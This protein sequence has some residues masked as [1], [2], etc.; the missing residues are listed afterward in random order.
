LT[1][2]TGTPWLK[3]VIHA[4]AVLPGVWLVWGYWQG[5]LSP[6]PIGV[7]IR[8]SGRYALVFLILSL[9]PTA[10]KLVVGSRALLR[11]RRIMGLYAFVYAALHFLAF[12]GLDYGFDLPFLLPALIEGRR[13]LAGLAA[14]I[15]LSPLAFTSTGGWV[16]RLG[17]NWRRLHRL[18]Y[19]ASILAV[20]HYAWSFKELRIMPVVTGAIVLLL[21]TMRIPPVANFAGRWRKHRD[22]DRTS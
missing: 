14:L 2:S 16:K 19:V 1:R 11:V 13:T 6:D 9:V 21:L 15:I 4:A 8:R 12:A 10:V 18:A 3:M 22:N 17:K 7:V 20:L 5:G